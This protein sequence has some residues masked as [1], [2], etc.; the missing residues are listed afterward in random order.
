MSPTTGA[1]QILAGLPA[2]GTQTVHQ[3]LL[4][5]IDCGD[6]CVLALLPTFTPPLRWGER[7]TAEVRYREAVSDSAPRLSAG[8]VP[9]PGWGELS[10]G[11]RA[12]TVAASR[13]SFNAA[14]RERIRELCRT[15]NHAPGA[16]QPE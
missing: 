16:A 10:D 14:V 5:G 13:D 2:G 1:Q 12:V 15:E 11:Q 7:D 9:A 8:A 6:P 3:H 4:A